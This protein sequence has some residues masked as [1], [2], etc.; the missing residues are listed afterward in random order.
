MMIAKFVV[1]EYLSSRHRTVSDANYWMI[2]TLY[3]DNYFVFGGIRTCSGVLPSNVPVNYL[4]PLSTEF[5]ACS[6]A[7]KIN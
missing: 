5:E 4:E 6:E 3:C 2:R 1:V 7:T